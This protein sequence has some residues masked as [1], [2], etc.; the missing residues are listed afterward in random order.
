MSNKETT[1]YNWLEKR[2][3]RSIEQLKLWNE[4]P[5]LNPDEKHITLAD[6]AEDLIANKN[7]KQHFFDLIKSIANNFIPADPIIVW[8]DADSH[9]FYVA[10]GNRRVLALKLLN[11]PNKAPKSIRAYIRKI[12]ESRKTK[13][14]KIKVCV[15]PTLEDAEWYINQRNSASSLQLPWSRIQQQRWLDNL[16][17][18]YGND[19]DTLNAKTSM[20]KSE[21]E[22]YIRNIRLLDLIKSTEIKSVLTED[23]YKK[24]TDINFPVT[25]LERFFSNR[26]V[27]EKWGIDFDGL[28]INLKNRNDF[29]TAY[30]ELIKNSVDNQIGIKID[31]RTITTK[32]N[33]ILEK[34]PPIDLSKNDPF[35]IS[36]KTTY[37][38]KSAKET[39]SNKKVTNTTLKGD[40]NRKHLILPCYSLETSEY[41]LE[42]IFNELKKLSVDTYK[43]AVAASIRIFLDLAVFNW[44]QTENLL[45]ELQS[46]EKKDIGDIILKN[47]LNFIATKLKTKS[48][49]ATSIISKLTNPNN[50]FSLDVLNGFQ[51]SKDTSF[52]DKQFLNRF[53]DFLFPLFQVLLDIRDDGSQDE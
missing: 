34:L 48:K 18:K 17:E 37:Q 3:P 38:A 15:A 23:Q 6:F 4:N 1:K 52:L 7:E 50:E 19:I 21:L 43:N 32:L 46:Q 29:F 40:P 11:D 53:W 41:R 13:L 47:R 10:E 45:K 30:A 44:L 24:A 14:E 12:S 51:H 33:T 35:V 8:Q 22:N 5:R 28:K 25:I 36:G 2:T 27:K 26:T 39:I 42:G 20:S 31:T 16:Y 49:K 9:K